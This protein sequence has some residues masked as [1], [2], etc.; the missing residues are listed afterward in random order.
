MS[1]L[2][3]WCIARL[4]TSPLMDLR[5]H[6]VLLVQ[7]PALFSGLSF[8]PIPSFAATLLPKYTHKWPAVTDEQHMTILTNTAAMGRC[9]CRA[10]AW[11]RASQ[12]PF[13]CPGLQR[14]HK[15]GRDPTRMAWPLYTVHS[16]SV[17]SKLTCN[18]SLRRHDAYLIRI[19]Q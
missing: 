6:T 5:T 3:S 17:L 12:G 1:R 18:P 19:P 15:R 4:H 14:D 2:C 11:G 10:T 9:S 7:P 13:S 16:L 8:S